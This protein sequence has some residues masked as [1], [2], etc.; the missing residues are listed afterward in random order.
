MHQS[1]VEF[2]FA[3]RIIEL[4]AF[5]PESSKGFLVLFKLLGLLDF[6]FGFAA[7]VSFAFPVLI[8]AIEIFQV[9]AL[10]EVKLVPRIVFIILILF[11]FGFLH[12]R[13]EIVFLL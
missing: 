7:D 8:V 13:Y 11:L 4:I 6:R 1:Y 12:G 2:L 10:I 5:T 3:E 9:L